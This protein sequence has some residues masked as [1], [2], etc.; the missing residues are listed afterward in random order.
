MR[1]PGVTTAIAIARHVTSIDL[2]PARGAVYRGHYPIGERPSGARVFV[3]IREPVEMK[4]IRL[5]FLRLSAQGRSSMTEID[6]AG[7]RSFILLPR[8]SIPLSSRGMS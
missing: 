8:I 7:T 1:G 2:E 3:G 4:K 6:F 5:K